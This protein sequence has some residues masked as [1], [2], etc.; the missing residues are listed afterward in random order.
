MGPQC[1]RTRRPVWNA[2]CGN[3]C[4]DQTFVFCTGPT[5]QGDLPGAWAFAEGR[6]ESDPVWCDRVPVCAREAAAAEVRP[7]ARAAGWMLAVNEAHAAR[8]R[9]TMCACH[10]DLHWTYPEKVEGLLIA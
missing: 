1:S 3:D 4:E 10:E 8:E 7:V 2:G 5:D 9:L 6:A